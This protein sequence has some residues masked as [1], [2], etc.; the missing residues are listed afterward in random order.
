M[1][2]TTKK[3]N[4]DFVKLRFLQNKIVEGIPYG[5]D[6]DPICDRVPASWARY[7]VAHGVAT[8]D[9]KAPAKTPAK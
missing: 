4:T 8:A 5:P 7:F 1:T 3:A 6:Y 2:V 9:L